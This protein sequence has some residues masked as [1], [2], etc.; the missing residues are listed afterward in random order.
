MH[1][2]VGD[3][4]DEVDSFDFVACA[5]SVLLHRFERKDLLLVC[6]LEPCLHVLYFQ[7]V[8]GAVQVQEL[9]RLPQN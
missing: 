3:C 9:R 8:E 7:A 2:L 6:F 5:C 4:Q 1:Q